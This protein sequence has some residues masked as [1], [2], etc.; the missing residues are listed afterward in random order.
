[1]KN[2]SSLSDNALLTKTSSNDSVKIKSLV[3]DWGYPGYL[4]QTEIETLKKFQNEVN[5]RE[6]AFRK[7]VFS[8]GDEEDE[9]YAY[10]RWLR[11][12]KFDL[13]EVIKM[14]ETATERRS[15]A[16]DENFY[17]D[18]SKALGFEKSIYLDL[19][20]QLYSGHS[21]K[22]YPV[23]FSKPGVMSV[24]GL[25]CVTDTEGIF[26]FHW[27][28]MIHDFG[29]RL[30][31]RS[32]NNPQ[33]KRFECICILDMESSQ[34]SRKALSIIKAQIQVDSLCFPETLNKMI[35][36]NAPSFLNYTW[37]VI[38]SW[39]DERTAKKI[40]IIPSR[41]EWEIRL[42]ELIDEELL[43]S[44]YGGK[45]ESTQ[46]TLWNEMIKCEG[47]HLVRQIIKPLSFRSSSSFHFNL[48]KGEEVNISVFTCCSSGAK[49][50]IQKKG[51]CSIGEKVTVK[52]SEIT[53]RKNTKVNFPSKYFGPGNF[54]VKADTMTSTFSLSNFLFIGKVNSNFGKQQKSESKNA[55]SILDNQNSIV[56][57]LSLDNQKSNCSS[58]KINEA[59]VVDNEVS[60]L[61]L[62][63]EV[64]IDP[65]HDIVEKDDGISSPELQLKSDP[66]VDKNIYASWCCG[67]EAMTLSTFM[68]II[69]Q[70]T[71]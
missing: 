64:R 66:V 16:S 21:K 65:P 51:N 7:T 15:K 6:E 56:G 49:F 23:L 57:G 1:M 14:V 61:D 46:L 22:G 11:A 44:D 62:E 70:R 58:I 71:I 33:F 41:K 52:H 37:N 67:M 53:N 9:E 39:L 38:S 30:R 32:A 60:N 10:C 5:H 4:T 55:S 63:Q 13:H 28:A 18:I 68:N 34:I 54:A 25:D 20:P 2:R 3:T 27:R 45:S 43:P 29:N 19:Y 36:I 42:K 8:F 40:E 35:I 47:N 69:N 17:P 12:R 26:K 31:Q 48:E 50:S 24:N 59:R